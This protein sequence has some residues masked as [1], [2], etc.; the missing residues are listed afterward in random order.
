MAIACPVSDGH[1]YLSKFK[2]MHT[3]LKNLF[4]CAA[5]VLASQVVIAQSKVGDKKLVV[6]VMDGY[7][8][9]ELL[10]GADSAI[11]FSTVMNISGS[12]I[13]TL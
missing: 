1:L 9:Q 11:L 3:I 4:T 12:C 10:H 8:W 7:R 6:V 13:A 2:I 5:F